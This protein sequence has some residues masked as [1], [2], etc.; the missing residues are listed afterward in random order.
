MSY[1]KILIALEHR[2]EE[3]EVIHQAVRLAQAL[4]ATLS[5]IHVNDPGAGKAHMLM[6]SLPLATEED[7]RAQFRELGYTQ[8][9]GEIQVEIVESSNYAATIATAAQSSDLLVVGHRHK[10]RIVAALIDSL[11]ERLADLAPCPMLIVPMR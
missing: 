1:T 2:T 3:A 4:G 7:I 10:S 8:E 6:D 5:A 11:D 9:A